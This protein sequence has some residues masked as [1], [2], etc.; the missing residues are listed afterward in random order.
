M[1]ACVLAMLKPLATKLQVAVLPVTA[2]PVTKVYFVF[3]VSNS[4]QLNAKTSETCPS[5]KTEISNIGYASM[6]CK[7]LWIR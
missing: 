7:G 5:Y 6:P 3:S 1:I 4:P 2:T